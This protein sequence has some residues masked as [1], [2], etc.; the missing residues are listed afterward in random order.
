[1]EKKISY[2]EFNKALDELKDKID[3]YGLGIEVFCASFIM[4]HPIE[5]GVNWSCMGT[6]PADKAEEYGRKLIEAAE[7]A[8]AFKYNGYMIDWRVK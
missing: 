5:I 6:V 4:D 7:A 2:G 8:K 1:M 3:D